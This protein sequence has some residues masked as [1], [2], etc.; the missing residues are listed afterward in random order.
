MQAQLFKQ[1][2]STA[3]LSLAQTRLHDLLEHGDGLDQGAGLAALGVPLSGGPL[4]G[5]KQGDV[6]VVDGRLGLAVSLRQRVEVCGMF[7][8]SCGSLLLRHL[9]E[10]RFDDPG[11]ASCWHCRCVLLPKRCLLHGVGEKSIKHANTHIKYRNNMLA[12]RWARKAGTRPRQAT[13]AGNRQGAEGGGQV[14]Q[15]LTSPR[16][17]AEMSLKLEPVYLLWL[18]R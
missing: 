18:G 10:D 5:S 9:N 12:S 4:V 1:R 13:Q 16:L 8:V 2:L 3:A 11:I 15:P 17:S 7:R 6:D 14:K